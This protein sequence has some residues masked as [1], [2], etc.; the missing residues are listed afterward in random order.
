MD[1]IMIEAN[2]EYIDISSNLAKIDG[3]AIFNSEIDLKKDVNKAVAKFWLHLYLNGEYQ[4]IQN[5]EIDLCE[6]NKGDELINYVIGEI[7]KFSNFKLSCPVKM[8]SN[9]FKV[10][11]AAVGHCDRSNK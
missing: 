10:L 1:D 3:D 9:F 2:S 8:V 11:K 6:E 7:E 5:M 4:E